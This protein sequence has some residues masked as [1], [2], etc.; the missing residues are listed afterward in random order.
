MYEETKSIQPKNNMFRSAYREAKHLAGASFALCRSGPLL[1]ETEKLD[2][3]ASGL[4]EEGIPYVQLRDGPIF[5]GHLPSKTQKVMYRLAKK[6]TRSKLS[7]S[8]F[9]VACDIAIRYQGC[10][11]KYGGPEKEKYYEVKKGDTVAE[12]GAFLGHYIVKLSEAVGPTGRVIAIE[13]I[14]DNLRLLR[15][16]VEEN[17]LENVTIVPKGV[18][19]ESGKTTIHL[20]K[21]GRQANSLV[22]IGSSQQTD[23]EIEVDSLDAIFGALNIDSVDFMVVQLNGVEIEAVMG[24][25]TTIARNIAIAARYERDGEL[26]Y[27]DIR[28]ILHTRKYNVIVEE[29]EFIFAALQ[30]LAS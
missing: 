12:M 21:A 2:V 3:S 28:N 23:I 9:G 18:W 11:L 16:N 1:K 7:E 22:D 15:K 29:E 10:G 13:P 17:C 4:T 8:A 19:K 25:N 27:M 14:P 24:L 5:F 30:Q 20:G 6:A 26:P